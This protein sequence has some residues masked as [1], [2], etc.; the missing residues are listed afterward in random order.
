MLNVLCLALIFLF[1]WIELEAMF[2]LARVPKAS[3]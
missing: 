2:G 1:G 3:P